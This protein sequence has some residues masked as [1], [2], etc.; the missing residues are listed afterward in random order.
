M[1]IKWKGGLYARNWNKFLQATQIP[2]RCFHQ[3]IKCLRYQRN[4]KYELLL[5]LKEGIERWRKIFESN[6][7]GSESFVT[8]LIFRMLTILFP[9]ELSKAEDAALFSPILSNQLHKWATWDSWASYVNT[10]NKILHHNIKK[11]L[12]NL[13]LFEIDTSEFMPDW[14]L[15]KIH[16]FLLQP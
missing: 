15:E 11:S 1:L 8:E 3:V 4:E 10:M 2:M 7:L 12:T 14:P 13:E 16:I 5:I 9:A 6:N